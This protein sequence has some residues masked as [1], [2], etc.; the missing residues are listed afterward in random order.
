MVLYQYN[1]SYSSS[2]AY[3]PIREPK[4]LTTAQW[5]III[6]FY[7][8]KVELSRGD[9]EKRGE[10]QNEEEHGVDDQLLQRRLQK[11]LF[12]VIE[13]LSSVPS[14]RP[15]GVDVTHQTFQ[16]R[17]RRGRWRR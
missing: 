6:T 9:Y 7:L 1:P 15:H 3:R 4:V 2:S 10:T 17:R 13:A 14:P 11:S 5:T 8:G 12:L 16:R